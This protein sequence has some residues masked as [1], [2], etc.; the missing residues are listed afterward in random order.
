MASMRDCFRCVRALLS[1]WA[2][3]FYHF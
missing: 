2:K 3:C 1:C